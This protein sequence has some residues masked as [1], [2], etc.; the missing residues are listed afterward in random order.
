M[1]EKQDL[2]IQKTYLALTSTFMKMLEEMPFEDVTVNELCNR[3]MVRRATFYKHFA[4]KYEFFAF[5]VK[6]TQHSFLERRAQAVG[7]PQQF[8]Y[9]TIVAV[10]E[11]I[12]ENRTL[13]ASATKSSMFPVLLDVVSEQTARDVQAQLKQDERAGKSLPASPVILAQL[14][15]G[16]L[17]NTAKWWFMENEKTPKEQMIAETAAL[18]LRDIG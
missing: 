2:R 6:E 5:F 7:Q 13:V 11:F 14:F 8:Y 17:I 9:N 3:A 10:F 1:E 16:A 4:D 12:D 18:L 15:T